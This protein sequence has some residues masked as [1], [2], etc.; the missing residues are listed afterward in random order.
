MEWSKVKAYAENGSASD[1]IF[2]SE[3]LQNFA[4]EEHVLVTSTF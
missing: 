3:R 4:R 1:V 2:F